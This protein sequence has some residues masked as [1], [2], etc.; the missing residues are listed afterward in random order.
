MG[1]PGGVSWSRRRF[2]AAR[3][4]ARQALMPHEY[5]GRVLILAGSDSGGGAG[6]QAD[7]KTVTLLGAYAATAITAITVQNTL[8]VSGVF[9]IP[10]EVVIAQARAVLDDIGA[11]VIKTGMLGNAAM[12]E[13]VAE[14]IAGSAIPAVIDPVMIAKG[15]VALLDPFA[16]EAV[17]EQ[18][19]P[20][21]AL[22]TP[23]APEAAALTGARRRDHWGSGAGGRGPPD[24]RRV[25]GADEGR[26]HRGT[27]RDR[28]SDD[29]GLHHP[30][31]QRTNRHPAHPRYGMHPRIRRRCPSCAGRVPRSRGRASARLCTRSHPHCAGSWRWAR[32]PEPRLATRAPLT[33]CARLPDQTH[34]RPCAASHPQPAA[35]GR[36][37]TRPP[38]R[39]ADRRQPAG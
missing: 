5:R 8:G 1:E 2:R 10:P 24:P 37:G 38:P 16:L 36:R 31:R 18:L 12:V 32:P 6:V 25:G 9:P 7:I 13:A 11:D 33:F 26:P 14:L 17:R 19:I 20:R 21:A 3:A 22:L 30:V 29:A 28:P 15:G 39:G 35:A 34:E 27:T 23:N 4:S